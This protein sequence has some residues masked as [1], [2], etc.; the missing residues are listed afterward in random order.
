MQLS[1][2]HQQEQQQQMAVRVQRVHP[3]ASVPPTE[4]QQLLYALPAGQQARLQAQQVQ[5][6]IDIHHR[7]QV[8]QIEEDTL[9]TRMRYIQ[10]IEAMVRQRGLCYLGYGCA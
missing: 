1:A 3:P 6:Q 7:R 10:Q 8:M 9:Q 4:Q 2:L 5:A